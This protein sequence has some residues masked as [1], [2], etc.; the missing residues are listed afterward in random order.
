M[1]KESL[2][3]NLPSNASL[4]YPM[5]Y[6]STTVEISPLPNWNK[7]IWQPLQKEGYFSMA[8]SESG[9]KKFLN[10]FEFLKQKFKISGFYTV[11]SAN[12]FPSD[13]GLASSA[14][15]FAALTE[16]AYKLSGEMTYKN[17][18]PHLSQSGSGSSCRS[19][20]NTWC[21][22]E[23]QSVSDIDLP[24]KNLLHAVVL[25]E[26]GKKMI[27]SSEAHVRIKTSE[28]NSGRASRANS[29]LKNLLQAL[30][31]NHWQSAYEITWA[32]FWDMHVLFETSQPPFS[33]MTERSLKFLRRVQDSWKV[34]SDGPLVTMDAGANVHLLWREDQKELAASSVQLWSKDFKILTDP[35]ISGSKK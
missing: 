26:E 28:N 12:N 35:K 29:R 22:W 8:L 19:F 6:L 27:S 1:G 31:D 30:R 11:R 2:T 9:Q 24:Q 4:S 18:L 15:S 5:D 34:T 23:G 32:E 10:H 20:S 16:A 3:G 21:L 7:D 13:C 25:L 17:E 14:S 33:Y